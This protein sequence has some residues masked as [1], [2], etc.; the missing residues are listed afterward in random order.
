MT[1]TNIPSGSR[2]F[3]DSN[4]LI[5]SITAHPIYGPACKLLLDRVETT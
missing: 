5:Y 4:T 3:L 1:F 2:V